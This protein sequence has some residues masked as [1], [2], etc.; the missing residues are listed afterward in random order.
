MIEFLRP[1]LS[2]E[3]MMHK[4]WCLACYLVINWKIKDL[5]EQV[6]VTIPAQTYS[7][8]AN[9]LYAYVNENKMPPAAIAPTILNLAEDYIAG[10]PV[11][12]KAGDYIAIQNYMRAKA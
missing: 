11:E 7:E 6:Q 10:K 8:I 1:K 4:R 3:E 12:I 9:H 5:V 2:F